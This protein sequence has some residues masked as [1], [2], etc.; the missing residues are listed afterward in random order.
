M[1]HKLPLGPEW[2]CW[3]WQENREREKEEGVR[4]RKVGSVGQL[5]VPRLHHRTVIPFRAEQSRAGI[6]AAQ[7]IFHSSTCFQQEV[8]TRNDGIH[9][10]QDLC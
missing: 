10:V 3:I 6:M 4:R 9:N 5:A 8:L 7:L 2:S 1:P